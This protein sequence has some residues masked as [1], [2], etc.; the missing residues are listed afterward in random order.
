VEQAVEE[1]NGDSLKAKLM[2]KHTGLDVTNPTPRA[3]QDEVT[4]LL[5]T[6][7]INFVQRQKIASFSGIMRRIHLAF[8]SFLQDEIR[9]ALNNLLLYSCSEISPIELK[10][11][12]MVFVGMM[13]YAEYISSNIPYMFKKG[14]SAPKINMKSSFEENDGIENLKDEKDLVAKESLKDEH[15]NIFMNYNFEIFELVSSGE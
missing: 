2:K 5:K 6:Q 8:E 13:K 12:K 3:V 10:K 14:T 7:D 1:K 9:Y 15:L 11:N 4:K